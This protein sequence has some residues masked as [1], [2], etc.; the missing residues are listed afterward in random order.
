MTTM[1]RNEGTDE[2]SGPKG[3]SPS[4]HGE[5]LL[6]KDMLTLWEVRR[7]YDQAVRESCLIIRRALD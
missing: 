3:G 7:V 1:T 2:V 5:L 4:G 6:H